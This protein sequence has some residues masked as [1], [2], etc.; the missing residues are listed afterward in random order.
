MGLQRI[1]RYRDLGELSTGMAG[2]LARR[3]VEL[4]TTRQRVHIALPGG[5][6]ARALYTALASLAPATALDPARLEV[7]WTSERYVPPTDLER[8][9]TQALSILAR[10]IQLVSAQVHPMP[11]D[12]GTSD[13]S[14]AAYAYA[15]ELGDVD[16][17]ICLLGVGTDGHVASI[18]PDHP[19][20]K[21]QGDKG[22][23]VIGVT[24]AP[25]PPAERISISMGT[26]NRSSE[27]WLM[28]AG[29][30]KARAVTRG[31]THDP[32]L[33]AGLVHGIDATYWF[34][35]KAAAADLPYHHCEF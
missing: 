2:R 11:S 21:D 23:R 19:S 24:E 15:K 27:V 32:L 25:I 14:E 33:P 26:I 20:M 10:T 3:I 9:S 35:D 8:N 22:L 4:Q 5:T 6:T 13:P 18:Y 12:K 7:W 17:D 1:H 28:A 31:V 34:V 16:F 30:E 29:M